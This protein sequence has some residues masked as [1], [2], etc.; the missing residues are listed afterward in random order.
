MYGAVAGLELDPAQPGYRHILFRPR[1][2][3]TL[4]W[5][6]ASLDTVHGP[7]AIRWERD[8][9]SL[10]LDLTVPDGAE[11]TLQP[12]PGYGPDRNLPPGRHAVQL[13]PAL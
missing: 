1:P 13:D 4:T 12:P 6:E 3:G 2:G 10:K 8:G 7:A 9:A 5:A 11:A